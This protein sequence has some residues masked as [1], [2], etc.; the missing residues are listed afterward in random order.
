M[1]LTSKTAAAAVLVALLPALAAGQGASGTGQTTRYWDCCKPSC[2]WAQKTNSGQQVVTCSRQDTPLQDNGATRSA[3]DAGGSAYMC[4]AHSPWAVSESLSY[5][6]AAVRI[7]GQTETTWCCACYEL[8]FTSGPVA[9]K[10]MVVQASNTGGDLG[11][12]HFDIAIPGGGVGLFNACT[13]Q[14][15][16]PADGWGE[17]YGGVS[18][19][20]ACDAFP[21]ALR[22]G[23]YWRFDWFA[24]ADN[25]AVQFRQVACPAA[26]VAKSG[27]ARA[28]D[29]I[30]ETPTGPTA[31][32]TW[33]P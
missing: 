1:Q 6:W 15:G 33:R 4:S 3:C 16:A 30:D 10:K 8:T 2:G 20:A 24:G 23:C 18:S 9:G 11:Q 7:A 25:P 14:Y 21:A 13:D 17:R 29:A 26:L 31:V 28:N 22:D 27:C 5:G 19:R 12:N 32:P